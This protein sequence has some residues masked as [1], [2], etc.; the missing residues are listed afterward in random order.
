MDKIRGS[1]LLRT[2]SLLSY[3]IVAAKDGF[4]GSPIPIEYASGGIGTR[5]GMTIDWIEKRL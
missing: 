2:A 4:I 3:Y 5:M 1:P